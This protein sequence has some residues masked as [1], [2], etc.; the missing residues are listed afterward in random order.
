M[1]L[2]LLQVDSTNKLKNTS[3]SIYLKCTMIL[4]LLEI[5]LIAWKAVV[6]ATQIFQKGSSEWKEVHTNHLFQMVKAA[7]CFPCSHGK[8]EGSLVFQS[9]SFKVFALS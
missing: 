2:I 7:S 4:V 8:F 6:R 3:T 9:I 1:I 5:Q